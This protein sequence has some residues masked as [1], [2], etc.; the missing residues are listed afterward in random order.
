MPVVRRT[1]HGGHEW[2][3]W[4]PPHHIQKNTIDPLLKAAND[5]FK[6]LKD[7]AREK[8]ARLLSGEEDLDHEEEEDE[9]DEEND[10]EDEDR[11]EGVKGEV[12][13]AGTVERSEEK[14]KLERERTEK[15]EKEKEQKVRRRTDYNARKTRRKRN[16]MVS[17]GGYALL[18]KV[19]D[20][21]GHRGRV[22][23]YEESGIVFDESAL[24]TQAKLILK[25]NDRANRRLDE[26]VHRY[27]GDEE[28]DEEISD[29]EA[30]RYCAAPAKGKLGEFM[31]IV[32][33][34]AGALAYDGGEGVAVVS[35][36][37]PAQEEEKE[38]EWGCQACTYV[39]KPSF[40]CCEV[41]SA[42]RN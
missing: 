5:H 12:A 28:S 37:A 16:A 6:L 9:D 11:E 22:G 2:L 41:C 18:D 27:A 20:E 25:R 19:R 36:V 17:G 42:E 8:Q 10:E 24:T 4:N 29:E 31:G 1:E 35:V 7:E 30:A 3:K 32:P 39:N 34:D 14:E 38:E 26:S 21:S 13:E 23:I 15:T 40:L 33:A